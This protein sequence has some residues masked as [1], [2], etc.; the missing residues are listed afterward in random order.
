MELTVKRTSKKATYTIG[1]MYVNGQ[2]FCDTLEDRVRNLNSEADKVPGD[3]AIPED[4][5]NV[6]VTY[7]PKF[8]RYLPLIED[9]PYFTGI[10]IHRGNT[11]KDTAGCIL[12]GEN[13][14]KGKVINSTIY[15]QRITMMLY[16]S[17]QNGEHNTI[18]IK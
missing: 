11:D 15:E 5:Y 4:K 17:Q 2:Y 9:V 13:T 8:K 10:R 3:T 1:R 14:V 18:L 6:T 12:V 16:Q 7:S